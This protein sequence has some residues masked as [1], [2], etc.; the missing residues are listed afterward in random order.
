MRKMRERPLQ[1]YLRP[2]QD[3]ALRARAKTEQ[4]ALGVLVRRGIDQLLAQVPIE[5]DPLMGI[6][7]LGSSGIGDLAERHD[8]YLVEAIKAEYNPPPKPKTKRAK[9]TKYRATR[10]RK[11]NRKTSK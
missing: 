5:E 11:S 1:I 7:G 8:Y 6:I 3:A 10:R 9:V 4:V 2:D